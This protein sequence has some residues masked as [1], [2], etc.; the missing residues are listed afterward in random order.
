[1]KDVTPND[2]KS[3]DE[4]WETCSLH[5]LLARIMRLN[6]ALPYCRGRAVAAYWPTQDERDRLISIYTRRNKV[7]DLE[8]K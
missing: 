6:T 7:A 4:S 3:P 8:R 5:L 2:V 1:M